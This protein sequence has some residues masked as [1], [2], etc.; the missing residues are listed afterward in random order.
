MLASQHCISS[1]FGNERYDAYCPNRIETTDEKRM[2]TVWIIDGAYLFN[3]GK[4]S[5]FDYLKLKN[6]MVR[7]NGGPLH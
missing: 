4:A 5:P 2:K 7:L 3:F 1:V 6:E